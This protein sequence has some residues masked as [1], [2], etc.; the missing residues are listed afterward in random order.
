M[1]RRA[2]TRP[3]LSMSTTYLGALKHL[4]ISEVGQGSC[5]TSGRI[6]FTACYDILVYFLYSM[7]SYRVCRVAFG[8]LAKS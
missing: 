4:R 2:P 3:W 7:L 8:M 1:S 6:I 5:A